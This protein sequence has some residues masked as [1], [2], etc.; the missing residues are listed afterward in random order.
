MEKEEFLIV[1][2]YLPEGKY[3]D[4]KRTPLVQG[5]G[6]DH[7][8]LLSVVPKEGA[9]VKPLEKLFVGKGDRDK[10]SLVKGV[11]PFPELTS[12]AKAT[13]PDAIES[14]I[15]A[16]EEKFLFFFNKCGSV[17]LRMHQL[18]LLPGIG[19]KN[20]E[21]LLRERQKKPFESLDEIPKRVKAVPD[22]RKL[23]VQRIVKELEGTERHHLFT[24]PPK[25]E[26]TFP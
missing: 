25:L 24:R 13:L 6:T 9:S 5:L 22:A 18:E 20:F 23:L 26:R 14:I 1:L 15:R 21:E 2:D 12:N 17:S 4:Y 16:N 11:L 10:I 8:T 3:T 7:F 19:R